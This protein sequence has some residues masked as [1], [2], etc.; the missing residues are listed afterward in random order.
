MVW[1][2]LWLGSQ[3][4]YTV[5]PFKHALARLLMHGVL[6]PRPSLFKERLHA[7]LEVPMNR[8]QEDSIRGGYKPGLTV[9]GISCR[10]LQIPEGALAPGFVVIDKSGLELDKHLPGMH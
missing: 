6:K 2:K 9:T 3:A 8:G 4:N 7:L 5:S 10:V 1:S